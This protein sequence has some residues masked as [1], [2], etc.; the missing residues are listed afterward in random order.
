MEN[1]QS[2][3]YQHC[4]TFHIVYSSREGD[5]IEDKAEYMDLIWLF[6]AFSASL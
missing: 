5:G 3:S 6:I 1:I 2:H 4:H